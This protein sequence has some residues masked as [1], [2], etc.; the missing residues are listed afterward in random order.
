MVVIKLDEYRCSILKPLAATRSEFLSKNPTPQISSAFRLCTMASM[1]KL[2]ANCVVFQQQ[3]RAVLARAGT[4][5]LDAT[6]FNW[7]Q[8][9]SSSSSSAMNMIPKMSISAIPNQSLEKSLPKNKIDIPIMV[10]CCIFL[11]LVATLLAAF[12]I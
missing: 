8:R 3:R 1:L 5:R 9:A 11:F 10:F 4:S 12:I 2:P 6:G 7:K